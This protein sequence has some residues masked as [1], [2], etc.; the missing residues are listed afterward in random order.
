MIKVSG[1]WK[2]LE[3]QLGEFSRQVPFGI[4]SALTATAKDAQATLREELPQHFTIRSNWSAKGIRIERA[5]KKTLTAK[6]GS[7]EEYMARQAKGGP[8]KSKGK[9]VAVPAVGSGKPRV[10]LDAKTSKSR[11]PGAFL[12]RKGV[13]VLDGPKGKKKAKGIWRMKGKGDN[14]RLELLYWLRKRVKVPKRWPLKETVLRVTRERFTTNL[15]AGLK[16]AIETAK[17]KAK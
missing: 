13:V 15:D 3:K 5:T 4:A 6:V 1:D 7:L 8:K 12:K 16:K 2:A 14:Q 9:D 17:S 11:W 10:T